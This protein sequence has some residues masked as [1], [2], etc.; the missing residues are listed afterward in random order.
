VNPEGSPKGIEESLLMRE[1]NVCR[2]SKAI[3]WEK[4]WF[5]F[6]AEKGTFME[7]KR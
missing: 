5:S 4:S 3:R 1:L 7:I 6:T 2:K